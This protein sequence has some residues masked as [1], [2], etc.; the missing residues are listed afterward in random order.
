MDIEL[1]AQF[2]ALRAG[3]HARR[4]EAQLR[5]GAKAGILTA[6]SQQHLLDAYRLCWTMQSTGRLLADQISD[7]ADLGPGGQKFI[8]NSAGAETADALAETLKSCC[9]RAE[10]A[11]TRVLTRNAAD[12]GDAGHA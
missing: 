12:I 11:I 2:C 4:V 8:L 6:G 9:A 3:H 7:I 10:E 1:I 5:A